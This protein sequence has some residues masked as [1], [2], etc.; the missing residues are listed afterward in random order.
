MILFQNATIFNGNKLISS[1]SVLVEKNKIIEVGKNIKANKIDLKINVNKNFLMP[2]LIDAHFHANTP[3]YDFYSSYR[4]PK[5]YIA[6]HAQNILND[7]LKRG[8][9][10]IRDAGGG[11]IGIKMALNEKLFEGPRFFYPGKAIT[12]TG[13]HGDMRNIS[14]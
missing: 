8:F 6:F 5:N 10:T 9:T 4:Y 11:D 12:Q 7:T 14:S 1:N 3:N 2:G 13:G